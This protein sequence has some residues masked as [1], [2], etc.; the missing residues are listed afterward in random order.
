MI[1]RRTLFL[2]LFISFITALQAQK[3]LVNSFPDRDYYKGLEL[4]N[5][6]KYSAAQ[7]FFTKVIENGISGK[8]EIKAG[9][10]YYSAMCAIELFNMDAEFKV[11][12]F[13]TQNPESQLVNDANF[14][15]AGYMYKK[16]TYAK[17]ISYYNKVDRFVLNADQL[18]EYYFNKG[19][20]YYMLNDYENAR[21]CF[22][23]IK[24][25]DSKY[26]S[27]ALYYYSHIA[28]DQKN[29]E[30]ALSGFLRLLDDATFSSIA[31][32]YVTQI[33]FMQKKYEKVVG[34]AP[35]L[36]D[37]V[38]EKRAAEMAKIIGDSYFALERY[39]EALPYLEKYRDDGKNMSIG[40]RYQLGFIYYKTGKYDPAAAL[41]ESIAY[42]NSEIS[43]S[44]MYN[45]ADC[46]L[47]TGDKN[48][49]RKAFSV[50]AGM[51]YNLVIQE[52]ALFNYAKVTYELSYNPFN[53][54]ILAFN[55]YL[56]LYPASG[57]TDEAYNYLVS[58]YLNTK[59]YKMALESLEK[60]KEKD[61]NMEKALQRIAFFRGLELFT[62][63]R[64][65]DAIA[66]FDRSLKY[67]QYD[68]V[69]KARTLYWLGE[70]YF[71]TNDPSS[72]EEYYNMFKQEAV[73]Y[74]VTEY[75][76]LNYSLG[77]VSF[78]K[79]DYPNA[80]KWFNSYVNLEKNPKAVTIADAYNRLGDTKFIESKYSEAIENYSKVIQLN[81]AD[82][83]Y[84]FFQ[85]GFCQG[86]INL[87]KQKIE[88]FNKLLTDFPKSSYFD[89]ALF[90]LGKTYAQLD[91]S[92]DALKSYQR[93]VTEFPNS[94]YLSRTLVQLGL[95][96][97]GSGNP[98]QAL[99]YYK[100]VVRDYPGTS[101]S[102]NA[103]KSIKDIYVAQNNVDTYLAYVDEIGKAIST[104]EQD[105]LMYSA[106]EN[107]Y[108]AGDCTKAIQSLDSYI[109]RFSN[110]NFLLNAHYYRADCLLKQNSPD[111]AFTSLEYIISQPV[112]IFSEPALLAATRISFGKA[113]YNRAAEL[114]LRLVEVGEKKANISEAEVGLMRCYVKLDEY[115]NII[116]AAN[117]VLLQ[118]K[119]Q[120]EIN[121]E[122]LFDIASAYLKQNNTPAA[123]DWFSKVAV[124]VNSKEGA[125]AK[126]R[127]A[128]L[129][130]LQG[131]K[132]RA[133]D[134]IY[135]Y[136][137]MNTPHAYWMGKSFL[138]LADIFQSEGDD[139]QALQTLQSVIDYYTDDNDG[140]KAAA[141]DAKKV[142]TGKANAREAAP[143]QEQIE[144][145]VQ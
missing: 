142:I 126:F 115:Q 63:L 53:E 40:D 67:S 64:F 71:R 59:N 86:L 122:A 144:V 2:V 41:F 22:Y 99:T 28:Y 136:I 17:C 121:R 4:Y 48:K 39:K 30:S 10:M 93:L 55:R 94:N 119:L 5:K 37:S 133:E 125:E 31:P 102:A 35:S 16:K 103:L 57:R 131:D 87:P 45:L 104:M 9:A 120:A 8:S 62:N 44:A 141:V 52:D 49:A 78:A 139:F 123:L 127:V 90:E 95:I 7:E 137:E 88:T 58:A 135:E 56:R 112:N 36:M 80:Q 68:A 145:G 32:Y 100:Q 114:Y 84:A 85:K 27:P 43:Q 26:S 65:T 74:Q 97:N 79:K 132:K 110:G 140:I 129:T 116:S 124:E 111:L 107:S 82:V 92:A 3:T 143:V 11:Y 20:S 75:P 25:I 134:V 77:Y 118:D 60:I 51:D 96:S 98:T 113:D 34:F 83:D 50:A 29:Y 19:Y 33:Y 15:I 66:S 46:Y 117:Q 106:A 138:L 109:A 13:I 72:A 81:K 38:T 105:S 23:E 70:A 61:S 91:L 47:K 89:D 130:F 128:E 12:E 1:V 54:A 101:E 21:I 18:S 14:R 108:L 24:D 69:I 6:E 42:T 73:A 76:M